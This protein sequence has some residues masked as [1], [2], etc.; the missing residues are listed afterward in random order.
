MISISLF[1]IRKASCV[2]MMCFLWAWIKTP[3]VPWVLMPKVFAKIL[4]GSSSNRAIRLF[5]YACWITVASAGW[6][7][8]I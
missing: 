1:K 8:A 3:M 4:A 2:V 6:S 5:W 7:P